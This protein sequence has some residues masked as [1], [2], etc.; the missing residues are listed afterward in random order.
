MDNNT[1]I[2]TERYEYFENHINDLIE[3]NWWTTKAKNIIRDA[4]ALGLDLDK[5][6]T[7][8][9]NPWA[10]VEV[11]ILLIKKYRIF[12]SEVERWTGDDAKETLKQLEELHEKYRAKLSKTLHAHLKNFCFEE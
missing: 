8:V 10:Y 2:I 12:K 5:L 11:Y 6:D 7:L 9:N 1:T 4:Y 3:Y